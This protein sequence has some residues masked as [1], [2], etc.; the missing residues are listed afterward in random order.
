MIHDEMAKQE[1]LTV[2]S[3]RAI[4]SAALARHALPEQMEIEVS[5]PGWTQDLVDRLSDLYD[6]DVAQIAALPGIVAAQAEALET[7]G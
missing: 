1:R 2:D 4:F 5:L 3:R 7:A 6:E